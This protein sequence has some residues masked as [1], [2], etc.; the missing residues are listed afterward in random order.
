M[1]GGVGGVDDAAV[2]VAALARQVETEF[3]L[4]VAREGNTVADQPFDGGAAV[5][6]DVA[7]R[8][9]VAEAGARD[10]GVVD[11]LVMAVVRVEHRGDAALCPVACAFGQRAFAD[12]DHAA[13]I[14]EMQGDGQ[15]RQ[16]TADNGNIEIH[17]EPGAGRGV[18]QRSRGRRSIGKRRSVHR[19]LA[20]LR[21]T[22]KNP[23]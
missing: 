18:R 6:D 19:A 4:L 9:F 20:G 10:Q 5:F 22:T 12:D 8:R 11:M 13:V 23:P 2:P 16:A 7:G 15:A 1:P 17:G 3:G 21:R 14:G